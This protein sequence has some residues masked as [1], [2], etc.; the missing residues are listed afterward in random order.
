MPATTSPYLTGRFL[1]GAL[2]LG[3]TA[4][5]YLPVA[6]SFYYGGG[7]PFI[8]V[9]YLAMYLLGIRWIRRSEIPVWLKWVLCLTPAAWMIAAQWESLT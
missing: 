6:G 8:Q 5:T 1:L 3:L 4:F 2:F 7:W 9:I